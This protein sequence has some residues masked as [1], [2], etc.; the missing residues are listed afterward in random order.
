MEQICLYPVGSSAGC[1]AG[2][3][4]LSRAGIRI[5]DHPSP[6]LTHLLLDVPAFLADGRLRGGGEIEGILEMLPEDVCIIGGQLQHPAL[7]GYEIMDLLKD[8]E[9]LAG[10]AAITAD[11][12]LRL[13]G[14]M[15]QSTF[16]ASP[17]LILGWG[18]IGK[19]LGQ[20][21]KALGAEVTVAARK[22]A[23]RGMLK[24][25]GFRAVDFSGVPGLL[26]KLGLLYNTVPAKLLDEE[27]LAAAPRCIKIDLASSPGL[28]GGDVVYARSL[29]G[30]HAPEASGAL[31]AETVLKKWKEGRP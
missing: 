29:P 3:R 17:V 18:R 14:P 8:E 11:C 16:R 31:I 12:A 25:L 4:L 6:E 15:L 9:Y 19:C 28:W 20:M 7:A 5:V 21:L 30:L 1:R 10:N 24:A 2:V 27:D 23:D 13:A 22:E 26:P